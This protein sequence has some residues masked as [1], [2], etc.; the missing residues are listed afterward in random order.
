[1]P[2]KMFRFNEERDLCLLRETRC[3]NPFTNPPKGWIEVFE[4]LLFS[5]FFP[6]DC[7]ASQRTCRQRVELLMGQFERLK[8]IRLASSGIEEEILEK[9]KLLEELLELRDEALR[10]TKEAA[11][12][13]KNTDAEL[14]RL[15]RDQ[16]MQAMVS[17]EKADAIDDATCSSTTPKGKKRKRLSGLA[18]S[19]EW[20]QYMQ[21]R[22]E[23]R[24]MI[25]QKEL[26]LRQ[27]ELD[28][29]KQREE[30]DRRERAEIRRLQAEREERDREERTK[31]MEMMLQALSKK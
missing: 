12:E 13:K 25:K 23:D 28:H 26:E 24:K 14:G 15:I 17:E 29:A 10:E 11:G 31:M 6:A 21:R 7:S 16:A 4:N 1:M 22:E 27:M 19:E 20:T 3:I 18:E 30:E 5:G 9:D 8:K 2:P